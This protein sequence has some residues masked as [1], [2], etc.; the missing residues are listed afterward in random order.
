MVLVGSIKD[1][2]LI[3]DSSFRYFQLYVLITSLSALHPSNRGGFRQTSASRVSISFLPKVVTGNQVFSA[4]LSGLPKVH[5]RISMENSG[6]DELVVHLEHS[7]DLSAME[8]EV[9]L[10]GMALTNG[11]LN[12][13]GIRNILS[14]T[15]KDFGEVNIKWV[16]ENMFIISA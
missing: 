1:P 6:V 2:Q 8:H 7:M 16:R 3:L 15:W 5:S 9:K 14:T 4:M 13:W 12:R 11:S 10:V